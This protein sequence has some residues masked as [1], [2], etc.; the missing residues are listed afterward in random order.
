MRFTCSAAPAMCQGCG[1]DG[2]NAGPKIAVIGDG[3]LH[4]EESHLPDRHGLPVQAD[5]MEGRRA[6]AS[7]TALPLV[8]STTR[9]PR[10]VSEPASCQQPARW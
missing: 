8:V 1:T 7:A 9:D 3:R 6:L 2:G 5:A 4:A 10:R